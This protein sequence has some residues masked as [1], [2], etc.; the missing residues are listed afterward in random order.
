MS[1]ITRNQAIQ[2]VEDIRTAIS[3]GSVTNTMEAQVLEYCVSVLGRRIVEASLS[4]HIENLPDVA[5]FLAGISP[6]TTLKALLEGI[7]GAVEVINANIGNGYVYAGI[8]TPSGTPVSGKVFYL[9][10]QAGQYANFGGLTV[11]EGVNILKRNGSTWTQEQ[12]LSMAHIRKNPLIGYYECDTAGDT[13]AKTVTAAGYVLP[14]TGGSVKIKMANRNTVANATLNIN[15]TGAKPL[16]YNGQRAGV[17]NTWDTN[18]IIEVFYDGAKYQAYNVAGCSGDGVFDISAYNLTDGQPTPYEDLAA[19]LGPNGDNV[20]LSLRKGGMSVKFLRDNKYIQARCMAQNFTTDVTQWQGVDDEPTAGSKNLVDSNGVYNYDKAIVRSKFEGA[21]LDTHVIGN[22]I[23]DL[24]PGHKYRVWVKD[25]NVTGLS[26]GYKLFIGTD[27]GFSHG[28]ANCVYNRTLQPYYDIIMPNDC[29]SLYIGGRRAAGVECCTYVQDITYSKNINE[30][31]SKWIAETKNFTANAATPYTVDLPE[32][33]TLRVKNNSSLNVGIE[34]RQTASSSTGAITTIIVGNGTTEFKLRIHCVSIYVTTAHDITIDIY[35]IFGNRIA[36]TSVL[37]KLYTCNTGANISNKVVSI[38]NFTFDNSGTF[39]VK[40]VNTNVASNVTINVSSLGAKPILYNNQPVSA[41]NTWKIGE[42][43]EMY[44]DSTYNGNT[45][46]F[47]AMEFLANKEI[48]DIES[49]SADYEVTDENR[50]AVFRIK[51]GEIQTKNFNSKYQPLSSNDS[52][53]DYEV[54][55]ENN[56]AILRIREGHIRTKNFDSRNVG[57]DSFL[58][59]SI[60]WYGTSI[61]AAGYPEVCGSYLGATVY[62]EAVGSSA[63]RIGYSTRVTPGG[64]L[65]DPYG[66]TGMAWNV[67]GLSLSMK[68]EEK[69]DIF[70]NWTTARRQANLIAQG[71]TSEEVA[72]IQGWGELLTGD[73]KPADI[74]D[75]S[76]DVYR[77]LYYSCSYNTPANPVEPALGV[78]EGKVDKYLNQQNFPD[79]WVFDHGHNDAQNSELMKTIPT[80]DDD[81]TYFIGAM[82]YIIKH[83][84]SY[85]PRARFIFI[86]HYENDETSSWHHSILCQAQQVLADYWNAPLYESWKMFGLSRNVVI[87]T[88]AYWDVDGV[89]HESGFD[90]TNGYQGYHYDGVPENI[91]QENGVWVHDMSPLWIHMLDGLHP[92]QEKIKDFIGHS[93]AKYIYSLITNF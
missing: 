71:Y 19:A 26:A 28:L 90:G 62:N 89:W 8:A 13:A 30:E 51:G 35:G 79:L 70:I 48:P 75:S 2:I 68:Q 23:R 64:P 49:A 87:T 33:T 3:A 73:N 40:F 54:T 47:F 41:N 61:P 59:K 66:I 77:K 78:I 52:L 63:C 15:S 86:G 83:I 42:I 4:G 31:I 80:P 34:F 92:F 57:D 9:A 76:K 88:N 69:Y 24:L 37:T 58:K 81:R 11:T 39:K 45:G 82:N 16:Y 93:I 36:E 12:L 27:S 72:N 43:V 29:Y 22:V 67:V 10:K 56:N 14:A 6:S 7:T 18:E 44:Y 46:G 5:A 91:R 55:D 50:N 60:V 38:P 1:E 17:G 20:P 21:G 74:M 65:G 32:G 85:N 84:L 53:S 25:T